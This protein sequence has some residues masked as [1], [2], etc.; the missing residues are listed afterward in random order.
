MLVTKV[1]ITRRNAVVQYEN[2]W[3]DKMPHDQW[4]YYEATTA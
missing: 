3:N 2:R 4:V 1:E